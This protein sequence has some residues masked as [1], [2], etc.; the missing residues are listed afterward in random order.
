MHWLVEF[1]VCI[2][3]NTRK[4]FE[5]KKHQATSIVLAK[6]ESVELFVCFYAMNS[7]MNE[8]WNANFVRE[9]YL[10]KYVYLKINFIQ[11]V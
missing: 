4:L 11:L 7:D 9:D 8:I 3:Y 10:S 5:R 2:Q 1:S 6:H